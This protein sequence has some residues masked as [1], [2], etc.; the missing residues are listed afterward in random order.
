[1]IVGNPQLKQ[2]KLVMAEEFFKDYRYGLFS[3]FAKAVED[4]WNMS[5]VSLRMFGKMLTMQA[6][7]KNISG[8][9]TIAQVAGDAIQ[10]SLP[11]FLNILAMISI[12]LGVIN[13]LPIPMLDGGHL[14]YYA[15]EA[16][17]G[18]PVS[19]GVQLI[20]QKIGL[21]FIASL[22]CLAFYNDIFRL[23]G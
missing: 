7:P 23:I 17:T 16:V 5:V 3:G 2:F 8:P 20:G 21:F 14:L 10:V 15:V 1:L 6:S 11:Y 4:T 22:M 19:E 9:I 13:L 12:S 18:K